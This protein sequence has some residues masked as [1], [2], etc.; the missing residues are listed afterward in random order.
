MDNSARYPPRIK[1]KELRGNEFELVCYEAGVVL[2][3]N[4]EWS[5]PYSQ[6]LLI[7]SEAGAGISPESPSGKFDTPLWSLFSTDP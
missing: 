7:F 3:L 6:K 4:L 5:M 2:W 1:V